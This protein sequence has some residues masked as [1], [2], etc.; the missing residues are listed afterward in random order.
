MG[1]DAKIDLE[2]VGPFS[3]GH[4]TIQLS[5]FNLQNVI[6]I[7]RP[8]IPVYQNV[9]EKTRQLAVRTQT[10]GVALSRA[11][12]GITENKEQVVQTVTVN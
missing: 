9:I 2:K 12:Q 8:P 10:L 1:A 11:G 4:P 5:L 7:N 6:E 3:Y